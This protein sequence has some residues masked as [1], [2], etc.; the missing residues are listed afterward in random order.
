MKRLTLLRHAKSSWVGEGL[1]DYVRPLSDRGLHDAPIMAR[2]MVEQSWTPDYLLC[3]AANRTRQTAQ[4]MLDVFSLDEQHVEFHDALYLASAGTILEFIQQTSSEIEHLMIVAHNPGLET[5]GRQ[6][7]PDSPNRLATCALMNFEI[8]ND[9][10]MIEP[11]T[12]IN[13][14]LH[15]FPKNT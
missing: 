13:F 1:P 15:D 7:H 4:V 9:S 5:L 6:L 8:H 12:Q 14:V 3:S 11:D 2:R 10:F